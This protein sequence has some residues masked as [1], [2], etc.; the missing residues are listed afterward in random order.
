MIARTLA[1][2]LSASL[3][4]SACHDEHA[5]TTGA[6]SAAQTANGGASEPASS[7]E[8]KLELSSSAF[9]PGGAM[10]QKYSC[11]GDNV[12]PPLTWASAPPGTK[13][14]ALIVKDPDAPDP[15]APQRVVTHW[16]VYDLPANVF[17]LGEGEKELPAA[18]RQGK[19]E[20]GDARYMGPCPPI[21]R[22][23]YFFKLYALDSTLP[24]LD[25]PKVADLEQAMRGHVLAAGELVGTYQKGG[26]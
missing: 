11:E 5:A 21:G 19:N 3:L 7:V 1:S 17:S 10:P 4:I 12:S 6:P 23:R 14:F 22:H 18:A 25:S 16:L 13:S 24:D 2:T 8:R 15:A 20:H 9:A 26:S